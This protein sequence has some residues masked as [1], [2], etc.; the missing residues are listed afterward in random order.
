MIKVIHIVGAR[1]QFIK[2]APLYSRL[3]Q[4][5]FNQTILHTGQH[6]DYNMSKSFFE[7]L[8]IPQPDHN[9]SINNLSHGSMTGRMIEQIEAIL[10][11]KHFDYVILYGDTNTTLAGAISAKKLNLRVIH[12]ESGVRNHDMLMPEEINRVIT[13][14]ISDLLFC[15]TDLNYN[16]LM[17]EGYLNLDCSF[18][19][20]GDLMQEIFFKN[21]NLNKPS[22]NQILFTCHRAE[23]LK[24]NNLIEIISALNFLSKKFEI[25]FPV[26]PATKKAIK[27]FNLKCQFKLNDPLSYYDI[28][29]EMIISKYVITDSGGLIKECYW[30]KKPSLSIMRKPVW[31]ELIDNKVSLNSSPIKAEIIN[32]F[33]NLDKIKFFPE[34]I[35][36]KVNVSRKIVN[37]IKKDFK[38][39]NAN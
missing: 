4:N 16:N 12:I 14:R 24:K 27:D 33:N 15:C 3:S 20:V 35:F 36:G 2:L 22:K 39:I 28:V 37:L 5:N 19:I 18:H 1:P 10:K 31:K 17:R 21:F 32:Q 34:N 8:S 30:S 13:D 9:L 29:N 6:Y 11:V 38:K 25:I 26:H 23:N 7:S